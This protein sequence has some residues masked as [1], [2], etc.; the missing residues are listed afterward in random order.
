MWMAH[1]TRDT[2]V[3][4]HPTQVVVVADAAFTGSAMVVQFLSGVSLTWFA[5]YSLR[6]PWLLAAIVLRPGCEGYASNSRYATWRVARRSKSAISR[7]PTAVCLESGS[8]L[9]GPR[10]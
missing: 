2:R 1:H 8:F 6:E 9:A 10:F 5:G 4:A 7:R 3:I